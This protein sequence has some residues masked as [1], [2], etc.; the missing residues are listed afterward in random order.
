MR[1]QAWV[2]AAWVQAAWVSLYLMDFQLLIL[3]DCP[4]HACHR[5]E[6]GDSVGVL[7]ALDRKDYRGRVLEEQWLERAGKGDGLNLLNW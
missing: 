4:G 3:R 6:A 5:L 1:A 7:P 2:Q